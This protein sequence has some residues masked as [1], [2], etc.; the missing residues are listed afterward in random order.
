MVKEYGYEYNA[1]VDEE[2]LLKTQWRGTEKKLWNAYCFR[3]GRD[4]LK[5]IAREHPNTTVYLPSLC[6][7]SMITPFELY[8][9]R[10]VFYPLQESLKCDYHALISLISDL[11]ERAILLFYDYFGISMFDTTQLVDIKNRHENL[12][13]VRDVTHNLMN[14]K[15][16]D[17]Y[18]DYTVASL[19]K[20]LN[21]PDG[22]LLWTEK[23]LYF[24]D[25]FDDS[26][27]ARKR[28]NAQYLRTL[29]FETGDENVKNTYRKEFSEVSAL[30]DENKQPV[31]MTEYSFELIS[32]TDWNEVKNVRVKNAKILVDIFSKS[33]DIKLITSN[34]KDGCLYVPIAIENRDVVQSKLS[35]KGIFNTIIWPL[36]MEQVNSC[37]TAK[38][39]LEHMLAVPCDQRYNEDDMQ[40][41]GEEIVRVLNE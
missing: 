30:L 10:V 39:V 12:I 4:A 1:V 23:S 6:C 37:K 29:Y 17:L 25:F 40:Y 26:T 5:V 33:H 35:S 3:C 8:D 14:C 41:I 34:F 13:L 36:R 22:G 24:K 15:R 21:I 19:R 16:L 18:V 32:K 20:W 31:K 7:D 9:C 2:L 28:L 27:F 38:Y 11:R